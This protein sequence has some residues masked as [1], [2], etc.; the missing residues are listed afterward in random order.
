[1]VLEEATHTLG[2]FQQTAQLLQKKFNSAKSSD[3]GTAAKQT[4]QSGIH[5]LQIFAHS[6]GG[7]WAYPLKGI[8]YMSQNQQIWSPILSTLLLFIGAS[9]A[10]IIL[11]FVFTFVPQMTILAF[12]T[13]FLAP[14]IAFFLV[15]AESYFVISAL[16]KIGWLEPLQDDLFDAV[17]V[18]GEK[19][20]GRGALGGHA[21]RDIMGQV[22][23]QNGLESLVQHGREVAPSSRTKPVLDRLGKKVKGTVN[24][25]SVEGLLQ[26][27]ITLPL[28]FIPVVGNIVFLVINGSKSATGLHARYFQLKGFTLEE[29]KRFVDDRRG[30]YT[31]FGVTSLALTLIPVINILFVISNTISAALWAVDLEKQQQAQQGQ[32]QKKDVFLAANEEARKEWRKIE[33]GGQ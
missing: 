16:S 8:V 5:A 15:L 33:H 21:K 20:G 27:L 19:D 7:A 23:I 29:A 1:M 25:L 12:F 4:A 30:A 32:G 11:M 22:L 13:F 18:F 28:N 26:Y 24:K 14:F 3:F 6:T 10:I 2:G 9:L 31:G 17:S